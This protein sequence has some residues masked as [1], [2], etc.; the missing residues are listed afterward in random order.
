MKIILNT[1]TH[2]VLTVANTPMY[3]AASKESQYLNIITYLKCRNILS[4]Y[5]KKIYY[6]T[7]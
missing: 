2:E 1:H 4:L 7:T 3:R 6:P 5:I